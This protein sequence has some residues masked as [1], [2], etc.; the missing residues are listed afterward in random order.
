MIEERNRRDRIEE[1]KIKSKRRN[2]CSELTGIIDNIEINSF[3]SIKDTIEISKRI[4]EKMDALSSQ[5]KINKDIKTNLAVIA[6]LKSEYAIYSNECAVLF[7]SEDRECGAIKVKVEDF[8]NHLVDI[9]E[10]T[11]FAK[12]HRDLIFVHENLKFG[13]CIERYEYFNKLVVWKSE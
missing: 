6:E 1:L 12:G 5:E 2:I 9:F 11:S 7:H 8:F 3:I 13:I 10:L 4:Y